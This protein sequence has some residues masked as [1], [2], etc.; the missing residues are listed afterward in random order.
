MNSIDLQHA[1]LY[2]LLLYP[3]ITSP[4]LL[5]PCRLIFTQLEAYNVFTKLDPGPERIYQLREA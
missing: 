2:R 3:Y 4:Y 5:L 1:T